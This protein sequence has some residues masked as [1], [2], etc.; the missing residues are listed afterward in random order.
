M[1]RADLPCFMDR[2][3]VF[4]VFCSKHAVAP[5]HRSG[6]DEGIFFIFFFFSD[7]KITGVFLGSK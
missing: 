7:E 4:S 3:N 2:S 6:V 1:D 5:G